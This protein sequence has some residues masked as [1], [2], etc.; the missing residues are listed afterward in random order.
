M[1]G[2][3]KVIGSLNSVTTLTNKKEKGIPSV[4]INVLDP[5]KTKIDNNMRGTRIRS[6][7]RAIVA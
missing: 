3:G 5:Q 2:V 1:P 7:G 4:Q 6:A